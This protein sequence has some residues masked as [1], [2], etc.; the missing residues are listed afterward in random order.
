[1]AMWWQK[2]KNDNGTEELAIPKELEDQIKEGA[3]GAKKI[4]KLEILLEGLVST[5]QAEVAARKKEKDDAD[6]AAARKRAVEGSDKLSE[7]IEELILTN[8]REAILRATAGQTEAIKAVHADNVRRE[9]FEDTTKFKYYHGDIKREV[10]AMIVSQNV[11]FRL[12][13]A[14]IEN[15]YH[16]VMGKHTDEIAEGKIKT[17]FAGSESSSRGTSSGSAGSTGTGGDREK[18]EYT[19]DT[20]K[21]FEKAAKVAGITT[22][23]YIELYEKEGVI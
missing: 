6:A 2:Q 19:A 10:D 16:T 23:D 4:S 21:A 1:M 11:D 17:R 22:K 5:Q 15:C 9:V 18:I 7:E 14:N 12:H 13:P 20:L 8:P 3:E